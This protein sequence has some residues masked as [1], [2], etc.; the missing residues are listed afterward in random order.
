LR[1]YPNGAFVNLAQNRL[2]ALDAPR[3]AIPSAPSSS[4]DVTDTVW[5]GALLA[6]GKQEGYLRMLFLKGNIYQ[7]QLIGL[8]KSE[9]VILSGTWSQTG[10]Q[11]KV[12]IPKTKSTSRGLNGTLTLKGNSLDGVRVLHGGPF[13]GKPL[14]IMLELV[15]SLARANAAKVFD[16]PPLT[17]VTDTKWKGEAYGLHNT[18]E[19]YLHL[20]FLKGGIVHEQFTFL[21]GSATPPLMGTW[22]QTGDVV[23][24]EIAKTKKIR[25]AS[26][27]FVLKDNMLNGSRTLHGGPATDKPIPIILRREQ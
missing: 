15:R 14:P 1:K 23:K 25:G 19:G 8:D 22:S 7:E 5:Q 26:G 12:D 20:T 13:T 9:G 17:D 3:P 16:G 11:I 24:T 6:N 2:N 18:V 27:T 10:T 4:G 21:N